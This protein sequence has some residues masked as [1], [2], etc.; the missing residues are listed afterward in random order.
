M[1]AARKIRLSGT[2]NTRDLGGYETAE[3]QITQFGRILRSDMPSALDEID[4]AAL[5]KRQIKTIIDLRS[6]EE[7]D[8]RPDP[9]ATCS[10][11]EYL[12]CSF[13]KGNQNPSSPDVVPDIYMELFLDF[14]NIRRVLEKIAQPGSILYHCAVGKDRT[15]VITAI[16]LLNAG[17]ELSD[18][19][20][21]YQ[22]SYTYLRVWIRELIKKE[23]LPSF[24]GRSNMEYMEVAL[25]RLKEKFGSIQEYLEKVGLSNE[26][27]EKLRKKLLCPG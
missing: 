15:G 18:V 17:V 9:F 27:L 7:M 4:I 6:P 24:M 16:L 11:F 22:V 26:T 2:M 1:I 13:S 12:P 19:L 3:G 10:A 14:E 23:G 25:D 5:Q 20:A 21:D 8:Y